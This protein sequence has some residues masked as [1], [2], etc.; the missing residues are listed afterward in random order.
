MRVN[1][2][3]GKIR[4]TKPKYPSEAGYVAQMQGQIR[5]LK[6]IVQKVVD[7]FENVSP[8]IMMDTLMPTFNKSK[9]YCPKKTHALVNSGYITSTGSAKSPRVEIGYAKGGQPFY[10]AYVHEMTSIYHA[11]PTRS[12][13]LQAAMMEDLTQIQ[14]R[15]IAEYRAFMGAG[16]G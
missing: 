9:V 6:E 4:S 11:P 10:G 2:V 1:L 13:F 14:T 8:Q 16:G 5:E 3:V 12:K 15:L 7:Q